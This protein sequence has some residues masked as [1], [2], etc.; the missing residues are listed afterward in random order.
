MSYNTATEDPQQVAPSAAA[1]VPAPDGKHRSPDSASS[2]AQHDPLWRIVVPSAGVFIAI[3]AITVIGGIF[4]PD[5]FVEAKWI[6]AC[7]GFAAGIPSGTV[8]QMLLHRRHDRQRT[9]KHLDAIESLTQIAAALTA[10]PGSAMSV[11]D[12]L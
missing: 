12:Q 2:V 4:D 9:R 10:V 5:G 3:V 11:L 6:F 1:T 7:G 8:F